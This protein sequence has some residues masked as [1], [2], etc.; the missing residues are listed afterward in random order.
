M[1]LIVGVALAAAGVLLLQYSRRRTGFLAPPA[2]YNEL[3]GI[4][5]GM[6]PAASALL[7][8]LLVDE[9]DKLGFVKHD[10]DHVPVLLFVNT[11][12]PNSR[13]AAIGTGPSPYD[14]MVESFRRLGAAGATRVCV[15]CNTAHAYARDAALAAGMPFLDMLSI[16]AE[17]TLL[18]LVGNINEPTDGIY[19]VGLLSTDG[20]VRMRL[21][22][23]ALAVAAEK[24]F[25]C[26]RRV[27]VLVPEDSS[28]TQGCILRI[29]GGTHKGNEIPETLCREAMA[30]VEKGARAVITGC[31]ELPVCFNEE[32]H[33]DFPVPIVN[34]MQALACEIIRL[35]QGGVE[36]PAIE[37]RTVA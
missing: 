15:A 28:I 14:G 36:Q 23:D 30:L 4:L 10:K 35:T 26:A 20:T 12:I 25:G 9:C 11:V 37:G 1:G 21:Y 29:K 8:R 31:T 33:P 16:A 24:V 19:R 17:A 3:V 13:D 27:E 22:Q 5:G 7:A 2:P 34:P 18:R 32:S 6:G